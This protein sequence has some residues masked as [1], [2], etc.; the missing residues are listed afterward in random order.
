M[1]MVV[2][3]LQGVPVSCRQQKPTLR[4]YTIGQLGYAP[5]RKDH[6]YPHIESPTRSSEDPTIEANA[7]AEAPK[8]ALHIFFPH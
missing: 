7:L 1:L 6:S 2:P 8:T 4:L 5:T 3:F